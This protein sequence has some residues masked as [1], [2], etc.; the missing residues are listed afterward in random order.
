MHPGLGREA[1]VTSPGIDQDRGE[2]V[3]AANLEI[4]LGLEK[5]D[6]VTSPESHLGLIR[7]DQVLGLR[8]DQVISLGMHPGLGKE[9]LVTSSGIDQGQG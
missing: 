6:L 2:K 4:H 3:L 8:E 9:A 5:E 7:E 1:L